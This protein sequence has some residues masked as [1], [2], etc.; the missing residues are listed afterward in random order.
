MKEA[1]EIKENFELIDVITMSRS[2]F[3]VAFIKTR[4][5]I[6]FTFNGW[7][8][9]SYDGESR[10]AFVYRSSISGYE[11]FKYVKVGKSIHYIDESRQILNKYT[12]EV[13]PEANWVIDVQRR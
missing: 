12:G 7:D 11:N 5:R 3:E 9:K 6:E 10:I 13:H 2:D 4:E 1:W 8:G